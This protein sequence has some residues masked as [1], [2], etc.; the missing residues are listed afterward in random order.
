MLHR[1]LVFLPYFFPGNL[2]SAFHPSAPVFQSILIPLWAW[3]MRVLC[4]HFLSLSQF[5]AQRLTTTLTHCVLQGFSS[6]QCAHSSV[7]LNVITSSILLSHH[8]PVCFLLSKYLLSLSCF[9]MSPFSSFVLSVNYLFFVLHHHMVAFIWEG[10]VGKKRRC[11][12]PA[13]HSLSWLPA[14]QALKS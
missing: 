3:G 10:R 6:H 2:F 14:V 13:G 12:Q 11:L 7:A 8:F 1:F 5:S 9:L 4:T